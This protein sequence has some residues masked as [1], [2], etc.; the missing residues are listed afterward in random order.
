MALLQDVD[1]LGSTVQA[2]LAELQMK[3]Q[4][5]ADSLDILPAMASALPPRHGSCQASWMES[6]GNGIRFPGLATTL[7]PKGKVSRMLMLPV[8]RGLCRTS[9]EYREEMIKTAPRLLL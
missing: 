6:R 4:Q 5:V 1:S 8:A 9:S 7:E 2:L 3:R